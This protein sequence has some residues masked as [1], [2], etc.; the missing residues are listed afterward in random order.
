MRQKYTGVWFSIDVLCSILDLSTKNI[1][2]RRDKT[3]L[4]IM[5]QMFALNVFKA[6]L[7]IF[8][9]LF[10]RP[11]FQN[12]LVTSFSLMFFLCLAPG[13]NTKKL[14]KTKNQCTLTQLDHK[15]QSY[16]KELFFRIASLSHSL[17][18]LSIV[19]RQR[20]KQHK[21][22]CSSKQNLK[23]KNLVTSL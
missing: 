13:W 5:S 19:L 6:K 3:V 10:L 23:Y 9:F 8:F 2:E 15:K 4:K 14:L 22:S 18:T 20:V 11:H 7:S 17:T 1:K 16:S 12:S 21:I